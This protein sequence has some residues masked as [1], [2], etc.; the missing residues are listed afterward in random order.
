MLLIL[1]SCDFSNID[2]DVTDDAFILKTNLLTRCISHAAKNRFWNSYVDNQNS[3]PDLITCSLK[4]GQFD[5]IKTACRR[6]R[7]KQERNMCSSGV[8]AAVT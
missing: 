8:I 2:D 7:S 1:L 5:A 6:R 4:V 3:N